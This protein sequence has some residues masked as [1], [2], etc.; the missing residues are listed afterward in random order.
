MR[1]KIESPTYPTYVAHATNHFAGYIPTKEAFAHGGHEV[2][3]SSWSKL[4]PEALDII[5]DETIDLLNEVFK[6]KKWK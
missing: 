3:P 6:N 1:I 4:I 5:V 2:N